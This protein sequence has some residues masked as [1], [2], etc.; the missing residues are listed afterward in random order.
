MALRSHSR[1]PLSFIF[2]LP[3]ARIVE[4]GERR[5]RCEE[6]SSDAG[7]CL[8][9][10]FDPQYQA[11]SIAYRAD[12]R[13]THAPNN[14]RAGTAG[15]YPHPLRSGEASGAAREDRAAR[16]QARQ[17]HAQEPRPEHVGFTDHALSIAA[18]IGGAFTAILSIPNLTKTNRPRQRCSACPHFALG[19]CR[20]PKRP[21]GAREGTVPGSRTGLSIGVASA[22]MSVQARNR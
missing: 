16:P 14:R 9:F 4:D 5:E 18:A 3:G 13:A 20:R 22:R 17:A 21:D 15:L 19:A 6:S 2:C 10:N 11:T 8:A 7:C 1:K 12:R